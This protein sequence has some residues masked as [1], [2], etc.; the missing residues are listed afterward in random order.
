MFLKVQGVT[1]EAGDADHKG[2]I[3]VVSWSWGME[4]PVSVTSGRG[5]GHGQLELRIV[6]RVDQ[7]PPR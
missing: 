1:G 6:K 4:G 2:E 7:A 3:E 5:E